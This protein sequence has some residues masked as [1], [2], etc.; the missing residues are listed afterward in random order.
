MLVRM[1]NGTVHIGD[2]IETLKSFEDESINCVVTSPPYWGLRDYGVRGQ[3]G[4]EKTPTEYVE[5][6]AN[7]FS[8]IHRVLRKDGTVWLNLGDSYVGGGRNA[9]NSKPHPKGYKGLEHLGNTVRP[10]NFGLP[11]KNLVGIPWRVALR[12]QELGWYLRADIIWHKPNPMP[13]SV[14]DRP[15][16]AHEYLFLLTKSESYLY[17]AEAIAEPITDSTAIRLLQNVA[18]QKGSDRV[19]GKTN[20]RMKAVGRKPFNS[21]MG[22]GGTTFVGHSGYR[23]ADGTL[24]V[25]PTRNKRSVWTIATKPYKGAH[26]AV[27][28]EALVEPCIMAGCPKDGIVLDPFCG[29]GTT[30]AVAE[31]LGRQGIGIELNPRYLPLI[32]ERLCN[33]NQ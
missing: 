24:L 9:G 22:G 33:T 23:K 25:R 6:I 8:E 14:Q 30:L 7:V 31:R 27:F 26:F 3:I 15:T 1:K 4:L 28:P 10:E 17:D 18:D 21:S 2:V 29:S 12:L 5:S 13:E 16:K 19:P 32:E 20:G 11:S